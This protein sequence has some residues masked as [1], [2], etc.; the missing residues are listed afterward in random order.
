MRKNQAPKDNFKRQ[1]KILLVIAGIV[2]ILGL[3]AA[4]AA[5]V[6][7]GQSAKSVDRADTA[8]NQLA[9]DMERAFPLI[10]VLGIEEGQDV[11]VDQ[12]I[13]LMYDENPDDPWDDAEYA[14]M[15]KAFLL[16]MEFAAE[17]GKGLAVNTINPAPVVDLD[18]QETSALFVNVIFICL[19]SALAEIDWSASTD[20][21]TIVDSCALYQKAVYL[22]SAESIIW[23]PE[24]STR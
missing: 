19:G 17:Q 14:Q 13:I 10:K 16:A 3:V 7:S 1:Q 11:D 9:G 12:I 8:M 20:H 4:G 24:Q 22:T 15:D 23:P 6:A 18:G 5:L 21:Q 2:V